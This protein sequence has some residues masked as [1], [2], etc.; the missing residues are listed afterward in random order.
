MSRPALP[1]SLL[2]AAAGA[3]ALHWA[4]LNGLGDGRPQPRQASQVGAS[5]AMLTRQIVIATPRPEIVMPAETKAPAPRQRL[6]PAPQPQQAAVPSAPAAPLIAATPAAA[7]LWHYELRQGEAGGIAR[8]SWQPDGL[9]YQARLER[10]LPDRTLPGWRSEGGFDAQGLAPERFA[11]QRR[12]RDSQA[13]NFRR[14]Q[15]LISFSASPAL[16]PLPAGVQ[17]RLTWMIQLAALTAA[18]PALRRP[19]TELSL[20]VA[21]LRGDLANWRFVVQRSE[22]LELPV[23]PVENALHLQR[24]ALGPYDAALDVWLDPAR[25]HLPVQLRQAGADGRTWLL[26]L[27]SEAQAC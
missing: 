24:E 15:G 21:G 2:W 7:F 5:A 3:L 16:L 4:L 12:G 1:P 19:G 20:P 6:R 22:D 8:L 10:E 14:A 13:T 17:D 18:N 26:R 23:G 11:Q 27:C 9:H 25:Q